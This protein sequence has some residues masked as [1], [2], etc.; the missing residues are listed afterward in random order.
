MEHCGTGHAC[1]RW[2][3]RLIY[4]LAAIVVNAAVSDTAVAGALSSDTMMTELRSWQPFN[5]MAPSQELVDE[6]ASL[7]GARVSAPNLE[8]QARMDGLSSGRLGWIRVKARTQLALT[9][10]IIREAYSTF[11]DNEFD[12]FG[13][14][15]RR[16]KRGWE[17]VLLAERRAVVMSELPQT[18]NPGDS[19][20]AEGTWALEQ[21]AEGLLS[22]HVRLPSGET[23]EGECLSNGLCR[24][25]RLAPQQVGWLVLQ[26]MVERGLGPEV[27]YSKYIRVGDAEAS[28]SRR[29]TPPTTRMP[30]RRLLETLLNDVRREAELPP[31]EFDGLLHEIAS[32]KVKVLANAGAFGHRLRGHSSPGTQLVEA[33]IAFSRVVETIAAGTDVEALVKQWL[34]SPAHRAKILDPT[35]R[36][37]GL[38]LVKPSKGHRIVTGVLLLTD[39]LG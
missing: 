3:H 19:F 12:S 26:I 37:A 28:K 11:Q 24:I 25:P 7:L 21:E 30:G 18:L 22:W 34:A 39:E 5:T 14:T 36:R 9:H 35:L 15:T 27:G 4:F 32:K 38:G 8:E 1:A 33:D 16:G 10:A 23:R 2:P 31:L 6:A 13:L 29:L 20:R 17:A